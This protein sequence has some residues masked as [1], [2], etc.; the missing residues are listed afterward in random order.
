MWYLYMMAGIFLFVPVII[1][2]KLKMGEN[3]FTKFV[4]VTCILSLI[5]NMTSVH[6]FYWDFGFSFCYLGYFLLGY[7]IREHLK[8][9]KNNIKAIFL[10]VLSFLILLVDVWIYYIQI[11]RKYESV[12]LK[13]LSVII[14]A[15]ASVVMFCGFTILDIKFTFSWLPGITFEIYLIH[16]GVWNI[17]QHII[18]VDMD[19]RIVILLCTMI[20]LSVSITGGFIY[21]KLWKWIDNKWILSDKLCYLIKL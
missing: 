18:S 5:S 4:L 10:I 21:N 19:S 7:T 13:Y 1:R 20:V 6:K 11:M 3:I 15:F 14:V 9:N 8:C 17:L 12:N 2:V 16:A